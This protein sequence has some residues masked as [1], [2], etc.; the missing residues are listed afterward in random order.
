MSLY[1]PL[2][3]AAHAEHTAMA[4]E[5]CGARSNKQ[6]FQCHL[7]WFWFS[8]PGPGTRRG[9]ITLLEILLNWHESQLFFLWNWWAPLRALHIWSNVNLVLK[10]KN[11]IS[12]NR[13]RQFYRCKYHMLFHNKLS[14]RVCCILTEFSSA[15]HFPPHPSSDPWA[16]YLCMFMDQMRLKCD[17][18]HEVSLTKTFSKL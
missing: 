6:G 12:L 17:D 18:N 9:I 13:G 10:K 3:I 1:L 16:V 2:T 11:H 8:F 15:C 4:A 14:C 7:Q 5:E